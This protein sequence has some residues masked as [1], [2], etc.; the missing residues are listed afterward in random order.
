MPSSAVT[1]IQ[2]RAPGPPQWIAMATPA[3]FP[4]PTVADSAVVSAWKCETSP[5]SSGSSY[6]PEVTAKPW[7]RC[8][9]WMKPSRMVRNIP[10]P[11][12]AMTTRG[13]LSSPTGM[14]NSHT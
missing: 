6:L 3:M 7:P 13:T 2:K 14:P 4:M 12:S 8:R 1:H 5:G 10:V 11:M 9:N